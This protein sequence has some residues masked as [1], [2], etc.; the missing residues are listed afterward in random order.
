MFPIGFI[1]QWQRFTAAG[2]LVPSAGPRCHAIIWPPETGFTM[3]I[4]SRRQ[5]DHRKRDGRALRRILL[6]MSWYASDLH[7]GVARYAREANW[8]VDAMAGH[9]EPTEPVWPPDGIICMPTRHSPLRALVR[10]A[11]IPTVSIGHNPLKGTPCVMVDNGLI[12]EVV[13]TYFQKRGFSHIAYYHRLRGRCPRQRG[14]AFRQAV[15]K[16]GQHFYL[17]NASEFR[18]QK[19]P[20]SATVKE[21]SAGFAPFNYLQKKLKELPKPLAVLAN[22]DDE[23]MEVITAALAEGLRVPED[24]AVLGVGNDELRCEFA[25][26]RL[27]SVDDNM[28]GTGYT[29]AKLLDRLLRHRRRST[30]DVHIPPV[31]IITR[32]STDIMT[33]RNPH[34]HAAL[35]AIQAQF[36]QPINAQT[37]V[38]DIPLSYRRLHEAFKKYLGYSIADEIVRVRVENAARLLVDTDD[39]LAHIAGICGFSGEV[40]M[41]KVFRRE[42]G[43]PPG[44][45]RRIARQRRTF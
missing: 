15:E 33:V 18:T 34:V 21:K 13:A 3:R 29:A 38:R 9:I 2:W 42:R 24:V 6:L 11:G 37:V 25:P 31:G 32:D 10:Y 17:I 12:G 45:F 8:V 19:Y 35:V 36:R 44:E 43:M 23:A 1:G 28:I 22:F 14:E 41:S 26:V 30:V 39:K 4:M 27:S 20:P 40:V 16:H 5:P 7:R